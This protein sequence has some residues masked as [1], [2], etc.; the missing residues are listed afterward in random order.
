MRGNMKKDNLI[1]RI[2][3][4]KSIKPEENW[5]ILSKKQ[6]LAQISGIKQESA[7]AS[8]F[9][10]SWGY[11]LGAALCAFALL[12]SGVVTIAASA[13]VDSPLY[14][15]KITLEKAVIALAPAN[16]RVDLQLAL[17]QQMVNDL[18]K[19][20]G[21]AHNQL[22]IETINQNLNEISV[23]LHQIAHPSQV[24]A[25]SEKIQKDVLRIKEELQQVPTDKPEMASSI[26]KLADR[27][28]SVEFEIFALKNEAED[29][30]NNCPAYLAKSLAQLEEKVNNGNLPAETTAKILSQLKEA[31]DYV[32]NNRCVDALVILDK[33][34]RELED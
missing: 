24:A 19:S 20:V 12:F 25:V 16:E 28:A 32:A 17:T 31:D 34:Q 10:F 29:K 9:V 3:G 13:P 27:V 6:V 5:L 22:A 15:V 21:S 33:V 14:S 23:Q 1:A 2:K 8:V 26:Q 11:K 18:T 4:L 7:S 30:I